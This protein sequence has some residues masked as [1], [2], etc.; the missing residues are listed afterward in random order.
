MREK[1]PVR[2]S[3]AKARSCRESRG[4]RIDEWAAL[5]QESQKRNYE[6]WPILGRAINPNYFVGSSYE[7]EIAWMKKFIQ[8]RLDWIER[9]FPPAAKSSPK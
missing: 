4:A 1:L 2:A 8:S 3:T 9:Q 7:E 5:L 6:R